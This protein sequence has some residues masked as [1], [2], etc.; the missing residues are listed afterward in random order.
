MVRGLKI[1]IYEE[2]LSLV[3]FSPEKRSLREEI[4]VTVDKKKKKPR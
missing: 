4:N 3:L 1:Q 2:W